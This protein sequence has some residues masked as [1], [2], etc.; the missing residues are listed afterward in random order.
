MIRIYSNDVDFQTQVKASDEFEVFYGNP[1]S[2]SSTK[3]KVLL[4]AA[5]EI[6]G[7]MKRYYRYTIPGENQSDYFDEDGQS[8]TKGL[9]K[10][11]GSSGEIA[12]GSGQTGN[13][14][15]TRSEGGRRLS[16][17]ALSAFRQHQQKVIAMMKNAPLAA[18]VMQNQ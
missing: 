7:K 6:N 15:I 4:Y 12:S 1:A 3:R 11:S 5:L 2:G 10:A 13:P 18:Q 16:G 8:A 9:L 14:Q 17:K